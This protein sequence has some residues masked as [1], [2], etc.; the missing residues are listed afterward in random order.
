MKTLKNI[1]IIFLI[2]LTLV[3][4]LKIC[5]IGSFEKISAGSNPDTP[6]IGVSL[7][8]SDEIKVTISKTK[9]ADGYCIYLKA[10]GDT[11]FKKVITLKKNGEKVRSYK[12]CNLDKG[13][14]YIKVKAYKKVEKEK[15]WG[16]FSGASKIEVTGKVDNNIESKQNVY[17][18]R[19]NLFS[20][21]YEER[22]TEYDGKI[23]PTFEI[24]YVNTDSNGF[25][26]KNN[27]QRIRTTEGKY[28][29]LKPGTIV[30]L[31]HYEGLRYLICFKRQDTGEYQ[32]YSWVDHD[33]SIVYEGEYAFM[34]SYDPDIDVEDVSKQANNPVKLHI[35]SYNIGHFAYGGGTPTSGIYERYGISNLVYK[36]KL[37]NYKKFFSEEAADIMFITEFSRCIDRVEGASD[38]NGKLKTDE[39]LFD[40]LYPYKVE[41]RNTNGVFI[42]NVLYANEIILD[43][44][45]VQVGDNEKVESSSNYVT[46]GYIY[47]NGKKIVLIVCHLGVN[48]NGVDKRK[49]QISNIISLVSEAEYAIIA[50]DFNVASAEE[51]KPFSD[52]G[53]IIANNSDYFGNLT[54]YNTT[55]ASYAASH[56]NEDF[57]WDESKGNSYCFDNVIVKGNIKIL[58]FQPRYDLFSKLTS[59]H[60][61]IIA[62]ILVY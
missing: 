25:I 17:L 50:G 29:H 28:Y 18:D 47:V 34:I 8:S 13:I 23:V 53:F 19:D 16:F 31:K 22:W 24:G 55:M 36:N 37:Q 1:L 54:T 38:L 46:Y 10:P 27:S 56:E 20:E 7:I 15:L 52:A 11:K 49:L 21:S 51:L 3:I 59:D 57:N 45:V 42:D 40:Y 43:G 60:V 48:P 35:V 33:V 14:Y 12:F 58:N 6:E 9:N 39:N 44:D 62:D 5:G 61:P 41:K 32:T 2:F 4:G 30:G 26:Y